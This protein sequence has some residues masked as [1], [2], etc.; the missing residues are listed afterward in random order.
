MEMMVACLLSRDG[1]E[2]ARKVIQREEIAT[3]WWNRDG[4]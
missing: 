3:S 2:R 1:E 4:A